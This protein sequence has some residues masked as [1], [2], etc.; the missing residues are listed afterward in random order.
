MKQFYVK[1]IRTD[2]ALI[3]IKQIPAFYSVEHSPLFCWRGSGYELK[4]IDETI[5]NGHKI[6]TGFLTKGNEKLITAWWFTNG[7]IL[8][9]SQLEWRWKA[10]LENKSFQLVNI[11]A[12]SEADLKSEIINRIN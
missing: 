4:N 11:T 2:K 3:Y 7:K 10:F 6:Y 8:T 1:Q 9:N 12:N 5:V